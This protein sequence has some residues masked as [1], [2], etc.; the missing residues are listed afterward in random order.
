MTDQEIIQSIR[1]K[2]FDRAVRELYKQEPMIRR[3]LF[4]YGA[5]ET[6]VPEI[7]NDGLVL[8]LEKTQQPDFQ[9]TSKLSTYLT[10]ICLNHWRNQ[11]RKLS[12]KEK[13]L[14][15]IDIA[16]TYAFVEYDEEKEEKLQLLDTILEKIQ[17]RCKQLLRLFYF[18][19]KRMAEIAKTMGFS[20]EKSAKTQKYKCMEKA[21]QLAKSE[22]QNLENPVA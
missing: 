1:N 13:V 8:L 11:S 4:K 10:G 16:Q 14:L 3:T 12:S 19:N 22:L 5:P 15:D 7:F 9:L 18:E 20:S 6:L 2:K 21:H 17:D